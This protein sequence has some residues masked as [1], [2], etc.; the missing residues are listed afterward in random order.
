MDQ[1]NTEIFS[2][3]LLLLPWCSSTFHQANVENA[4]NDSEDNLLF[5]RIQSLQRL[6]KVDSHDEE[7]WPV[8]LT[9]N[10][11]WAN[12]LVVQYRSKL[13]PQEEKFVWMSWQKYVFVVLIWPFIGLQNHPHSILTHI[14]RTAFLRFPARCCSPYCC[15]SPWPTYSSHEKFWHT[16]EN[17]PCS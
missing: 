3:V 11:R 13:F 6:L 1:N 16:S 8:S 5:F 2:C 9:L 12:N 10:N 17:G 14:L 7:D 4:Q 15:S